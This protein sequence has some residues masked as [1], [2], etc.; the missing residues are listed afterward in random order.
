MTYTDYGVLITNLYHKMLSCMDLNKIA[1]K[2]VI[3]NVMDTGPFKYIPLSYGEM[4]LNSKCIE[5]GNVECSY[6]FVVVRLT[7]H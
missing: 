2:D 4:R 3:Y 5:S 6:R 1:S 7:V